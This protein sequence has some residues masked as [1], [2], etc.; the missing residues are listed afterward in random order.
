MVPT[1]KGDRTMTAIRRTPGRAFATVFAL[2][3]PLLGGC[4][5][6]DVQLNGKIFD[7]LGV[8]STTANKDVRMAERAPLVV[9]PGL[10]RLPAPGSGTAT[11]TGA[12]AEI[13]DPDAAK[14]AN[15]GDLERQ[16]A[17]YCQKHYE[18]PKA[19]GD[20][21]VDGVKGPLGPCRA[22]VLTALPKLFK[23][24]APEE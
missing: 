13:K 9:P 20:D 23:D 21:T 12:L 22:S 1:T 17:T 16:Q 7:A 24:D 11:E 18:E 15:R 14:S 3:L 6:G 4:A 5:A 2:A 8:N 19:R 10:E